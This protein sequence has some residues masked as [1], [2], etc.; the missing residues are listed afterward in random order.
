MIY[1]CMR[2]NCGFLF[3]RTTEPDACPDCGGKNIRVAN[4]AEQREYENR[5]TVLDSNSEKD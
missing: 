4:D 5:K 3:S 1:K 2:E